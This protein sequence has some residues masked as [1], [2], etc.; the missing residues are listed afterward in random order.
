MQRRTLTALLLAFAMVLL[1]SAAADAA[2]TTTCKSTDM[3]YPFEPGGP[4]TFGVHKL[5]VTGGTCEKARTVARAWMEEFEANLK[6]G[7]VKLPRSVLGFTFTTLK[8]TEAQT[9]NERGRKGGTTI[10]F[11]YVVPNG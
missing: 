3:R 9:Y 10:R 6:K 8:P 5:R 7:R 1:P 2:S 11:S 4:K